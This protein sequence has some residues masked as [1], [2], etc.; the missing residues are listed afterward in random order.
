MVIGHFRPQ[1]VLWHFLHYG[2]PDPEGSGRVSRQ[3]LKNAVIVKKLKS[4]NW[5]LKILIN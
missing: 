2:H 4:L 3:V 1:N 5:H